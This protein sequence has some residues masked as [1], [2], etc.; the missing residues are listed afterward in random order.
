MRLPLPPSF[1]PPRWGRGCG[2]GAP[3]PPPLPVGNSI[4]CPSGCC[5]MKEGGMVAGSKPRQGTQTDVERQRWGGLCCVASQHVRR[6]VAAPLG[7]RGRMR[8]SL[9]LPFTAAFSTGRFV[10]CFSSF[11]RGITFKN[12]EKRRAL[13]WKRWVIAKL[14]AA[15]AIIVY[16]YMIQLM[17]RFKHPSV[18]QSNFRAITE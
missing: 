10:C 8:T 2:P 12:L 13:I 17:S 9:S 1:Y 7:N 16:E 11:H 3:C 4:S 5:G 15:N 6:H 14:R 18:A